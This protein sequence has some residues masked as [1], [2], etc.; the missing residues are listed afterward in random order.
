MVFQNP[1]TRTKTE[2]IIICLEEFCLDYLCDDCPIKARAGNIP[3]YD[4]AKQNPVETAHII[5]YEILDEPGHFNTYAN[6]NYNI[7]M[8]TTSDKP[9]ICHLLGIE[10]GEWFYMSGVEFCVNPEGDLVT[11]DGLPHFQTLVRTL[12]HPE[13]IVYTG[14][15]FPDPVDNESKYKRRD[16]GKYKAEKPEV[17]E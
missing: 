15:M 7:P 8:H 4:F 16:G 1:K 10:H 9:R 17:V 2:S 5:G 3:C 13:G 11:R 6:K 14:N 12:N